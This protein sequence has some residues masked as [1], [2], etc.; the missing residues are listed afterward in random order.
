M[1]RRFVLAGATLA[2]AVREIPQVQESVLHKHRH[3][4]GHLMTRFTAVLLACLVL[5]VLLVLP[6][7]AAADHAT[8]PHTD[9]LQALGHSPFPATFLGQP[10][11]V[12]KP[13]SDL[14]FWGG[15]I[16]QGNYDGFRIIRRSD[17]SVVSHPSCNGDQGDLV[18]WKNIVVR[19]W[20]SKKTGP[21]MCDGEVVPAGFEGVHVFDISNLADPDLVAQVALPCGSHTATLAPDLKNERVI[22]YSNNSSSTGCVDGTQAADDPVGDFIDVIEVP[23]DDPSQT[24]LLRREPLSG[25]PVTG[26]RTGCHDMGV[27]QGN[28]NLAACASADATNVYDVGRNQ[29]PGGSLDNPRFLYAITE[30]GVGQ[31]GTNGRWHSATFTWDGEVLVLGWEP[32]GGAEPECQSTDPAVDKSAFFYNAHTGAKLGQWTL[33]RGQDGAAENCTIHNYN[34]VPLKN[35][36][37][38]MVGGHYQAGTWVVDFTNPAAARTVAWSDPPALVPPDLGG[39]WS[40]YW[41]NDRIYE[42]EIT[43]GL[44]VFR[45]KDRVVKSA[46]HLRHRN[47]QTQEFSL[48]HGH[49]DGHDRH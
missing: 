22:V 16:F 31:A 12:R 45:L 36:R 3:R 23:L 39:A 6:T 8:R 5:L 41:Y 26:V 33:P 11:G 18:V 14:A 43:K 49:S 40:S 32:G 38:V 48:D 7:T 2:I 46:K 27:I 21:R 10:D 4:H 1:R 24:E 37:Y 19:S 35:G 42:S 28:V 9:N 29:H 44:N 20:N 15:L 13:S 30:P 17:L 25:S 47:P 34:V